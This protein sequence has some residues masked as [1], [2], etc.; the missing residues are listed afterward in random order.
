MRPFSR[1]ATLCALWAVAAVCAQP[2]NEAR[3]KAKLAYNMARFTQWPGEAFPT[4]TAPLLLCLLQRSETLAAAFTELEGLTVGGH[5]V[6]V[7]FHPSKELKECHVVFMHESVSN[8]RVTSALAD[9]AGSPVLTIGDMARFADR[10]GMVELVI[11]NDAIRFDVNL[12][13]LRSAQL[14]LSSQVLKLARQVRG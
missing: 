6:K 2:L 12:K 4:P 8:T 7:E 11:V 10:G 5:P 1:F 14:A 13:E 9:L 3:V